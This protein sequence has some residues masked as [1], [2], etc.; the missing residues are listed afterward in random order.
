MPPEEAKPIMDV[1]GA[2][3]NNDSYTIPM[4][5]ADDDITDQVIGNLEGMNGSQ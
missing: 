4:V 1:G 5:I 2:N 3:V